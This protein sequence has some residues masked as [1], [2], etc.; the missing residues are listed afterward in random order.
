M[1][2]PICGA[3][4]PRRRSGTARSSSRSTST[5]RAFCEAFRFRPP[6]RLFLL[7]R[8]ELLPLRND[9]RA[10]GPERKL[11]GIVVEPVRQPP[12]GQGVLGAAARRRAARIGE[13][14]GAFAFEIRNARMVRF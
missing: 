5:R 9:E 6:C 14:A 11:V 2:P 7:P 3:G 13:R 12:I 4:S 1:F 8:R 10:L